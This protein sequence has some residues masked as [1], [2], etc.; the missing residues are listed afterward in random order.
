MLTSQGVFLVFSNLSEFMLHDQEH[1][2][3]RPAC[4]V[5]LPISELKVTGIQNSKNCCV[6]KSYLEDIRDVMSQK[7]GRI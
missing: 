4:T 2:H 7:H 1:R 3:L 6:L 5:P